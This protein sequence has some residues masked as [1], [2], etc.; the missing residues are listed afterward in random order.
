[1]LFNKNNPN[2]KNELLD[3]IYDRILHNIIKFIHIKEDEDFYELCLKYCYLLYDRLSN[4]AFLRQLLNAYK[5][6][7]LAEKIQKLEILEKLTFRGV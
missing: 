2:P 3:G 5:S 7:S 1:M 6:Y 4:D